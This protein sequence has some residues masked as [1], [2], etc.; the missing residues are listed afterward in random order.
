[1]REMLEEADGDYQVA[2]ARCKKAIFEGRLWDMIPFPYPTHV[3]FYEYPNY[4]APNGLLE[5]KNFD[6]DNYI[7]SI[8]LSTFSF[9]S[10]M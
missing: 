1:L 8:S 3:L 7:F 6:F 10:F 2:A 4:I 9:S 5:W